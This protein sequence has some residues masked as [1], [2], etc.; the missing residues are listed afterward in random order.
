MTMSSLIKVVDVVF[1]LK[2]KRT[3][4]MRLTGQLGLKSNLKGMIMINWLLGRELL[5]RFYLICKLLY[6][7][8]A[9]I[10]L[11]IGKLILK[12]KKNGQK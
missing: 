10:F 1:H 4:L 5:F 11:H 2:A 3:S 9:D 8:L 6:V 7:C 12:I